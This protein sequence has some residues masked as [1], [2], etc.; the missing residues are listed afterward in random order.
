[1]SI[2]HFSTSSIHAITVHPIIIIKVLI[3]KVLKNKLLLL[4][5]LC[6]QFFLMH[7]KLVTFDCLSLTKGP[8]KPNFLPLPQPRVFFLQNFQFSGQKFDV[9][10]MPLK[11]GCS[12][13]TAQFAPFCHKFWP[14]TDRLVIA[15]KRPFHFVYFNQLISTVFSVYQF[16]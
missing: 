16:E 11:I 6:N 3:L 1:M 15:V 7:A 12:F 4:L 14:G 10:F 8:I 2:S 13:F 5:L 9:Y